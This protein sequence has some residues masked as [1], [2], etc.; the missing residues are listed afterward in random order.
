MIPR[1]YPVVRSTTI[2]TPR[3]RLPRLQAFSISSKMVAPT[4]KLNS[5]Y[6]MPL[7][8]FGLWK[9]SNET[10]ADQIYKAIQAGYRCFDGA[11]GE[12]Q[13]RKPPRSSLC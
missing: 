5:G 13:A 9:V 12:H 7:V 1:V 3:Q 2:L 10:C 4:V 8:G 6:D 11:C